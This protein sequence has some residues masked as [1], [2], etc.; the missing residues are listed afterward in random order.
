MYSNCGYQCRRE[1]SLDHNELDGRGFIY[2]SLEHSEGE[3]ETKVDGLCVPVLDDKTMQFE[4]GKEGPL[5]PSL[6]TTQTVN[7]LIRWAGQWGPCYPMD[8][9]MT[10]LASKPARCRGSGVPLQVPC[11]VATQP[12]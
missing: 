3:D 4:R 1:A 11:P 10:P 7:S 8:Q 9:Q 5:G 12:L 2:H 6:L